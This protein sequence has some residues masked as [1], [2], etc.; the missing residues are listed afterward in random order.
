S[1]A[2]SKKKNSKIII[3]ISIILLLAGVGLIYGAW[4]FV[5]QTS[6]VALEPNIPLVSSEENIEIN[7]TSK[8]KAEIISAIG[9][10]KEDPAIP[11]SISNLYFTI[12]S[13]EDG[14]RLA[15]LNEIWSKSELS[16]PIDLTHFLTERYMFGIHHSSSNN[17]F[18]I[19]S[20]SSFV[21]TLD[22]MLKFEQ[23]IT[24]QLLSLYGP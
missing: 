5:Q 22:A 21:N 8:T 17:P 20:T 14:K 23:Q 15:T 16:L 10:I 19:L 4:F 7:L 2:E 13:E 24:T 12:E 1:R 11:D 6:S 18:V 9:K 3:I